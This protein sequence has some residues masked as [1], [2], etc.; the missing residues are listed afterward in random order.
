MRH[1]VENEY[2]C[3]KIAKAYGFDV[4]NCEII[5]PD[6]IKALAVERFDRK[7]S[8]DGSWIIRLPQEDFCQVTGTSPARKYETDGG[9]AVSQIMKELLGSV[10]PIEDRYTFMRAQVLF[11]LLGATDGHAKNFS[12]FIERENRYRLTP[13]YDILSAFPAINKRVCT[14]KIS[15]LPCH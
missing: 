10:T 8:P 6:G 3:L 2:L 12:V 11:W 15:G 9:P 7:Q 1:S 13:L 4:A 14:K 5:T